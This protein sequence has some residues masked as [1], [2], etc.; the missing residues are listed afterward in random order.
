MRLIR[1]TQESFFEG[2]KYAREGYRLSDI[3]AAVQAYAESQGYSIVR[4]VCGSRHRALYARAARGAN[5][6][7][8]GHG[9]RLLRGMTIAVEPMVN[10]GSAAIVQMSDGWTVRTAD[11]KMPPTMR[12]PF[13][14]PPATRS[15]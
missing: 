11:G 7:K 13:S 5:Y 10:A 15:F 2:L 6:G 9:P 8:P 4:E 12:T 14:S 3:S 1:V